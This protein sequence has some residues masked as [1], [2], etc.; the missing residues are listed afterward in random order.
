MA[1][2]DPKIEGL[3]ARK[4][5][6]ERHPN[7]EAYFFDAS[8][9]LHIAVQ[10]EGDI[11]SLHT[12][13]FEPTQITGQMAFGSPNIN[14]VEKLADIPTVTSIESQVRNV[15]QLSDSVP[16]IAA[17]NI[18]TR[19][20]DN[21]NGYT[22]RGVIVGIIDTGINFGHE[23][24]KNPDGTTRIISIWDQT[25]NAPVN[26]PQ[27]GETAPT[28]IT[29]GPFQT[30]LGYGVEY[31][32]NQ[33]NDTINNSSPAIRVRHK[34]DDGHGT[35]VAGIAA[36]NGKQPGGCHG[37]YHYIGVAPEA[38]LVIVRLWGLSD[39]DRGEKMNPP[40]SPA[41]TAPGSNLVG[42]ALNYI[43]NKGIVESKPVVINCSFGF[44]GDR[45]DGSDGTSTT[46]NTLLTAN[47]A[48]RAVVWAAGNDGNRNFH[49]TGSVPASGQLQLR[50]KI[51][52]SD[53][54]VRQIRI[55]YS[56]SN[57]QPQIISPVGGA[58][59]T[60]AWVTQAASPV[61]SNTANGANGSVTVT[62]VPNRITITIDPDRASPPAAAQSPP[63]T[64]TPNTGSND[65][66]ILLRDTAATATTID[67]FC[68]GGSSHDRKSPKFLN[69][70]T[71]NSTLTQQASG[72]DCITVG[73]HIIGGQ[74]VA[75]SGRGPTTDTPPRT[76]PELTA[77]G[78]DISSTGIPEDICANC[79]C[80]C[81]RDYYVSKGGTSMAAP[82]IA[83]TVA[84]MLHKNP[85]LPH[86]Q[87]KTLLTANVGA[88]PP[89]DAP[90]SDLPGW[91]AGRVSAMNSVNVTA[92]VNPPDAFVAPT[93]TEMAEPII[94]QRFRDTKFGELYY[95]L[96]LKYSR[97]IL[98]LINTNKRVATRW[99]R[100]KGPIWVRHAL[101]AFNNPN[102]EIPL[103]VH[104]TGIAESAYSF[105]EILK[106][107]G[108]Q[109][110][111]EDLERCLQH[112]R[113]FKDGMTLNEMMN[114]LGS[115]PL[116]LEE[117]QHIRTRAI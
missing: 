55:L 3:L 31:S 9:T 63:R 18:W 53:S 39:G 91:G 36:G 89:G 60:V 33:I 41:V 65:W 2:L 26:P 94:L 95:K 11:A 116:H 75:S 12:S 102:K 87:I 105:A 59:G 62:N 86:T 29:T 76:K 78:D 67:A 17:N 14:V 117:L 107:H 100:S 61:S 27:G 108:S 98:N 30:P 115:Q 37:A 54:E 64:N 1:W 44:F 13:G 32:A 110:L 23:N 81:C 40:A 72:R 106:V 80:Q 90:P 50:F 68:I 4:K 25:I 71:T 21:F 79:C 101:T 48:G 83:G 34:D 85:N 69:N 73:S 84:L 88:T 43:F 103:Q 7:D 38:E 112:I 46:V 52:P 96:G 104:G 57:L 92:V 16:D 8:L 74:L 51:Y 28:A 15:I 22:G 5:L 45:M 35:H 58:N 6:Q 111:R 66:Q 70:T 10:F 113:L 42:D 97:E 47:P 109:D 114:L 19:V 77:P 99:H 49:A 20:G 93:A 24:F 82:H 56:G